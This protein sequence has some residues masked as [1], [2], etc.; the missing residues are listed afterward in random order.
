MCLLKLQSCCYVD[1]LQKYRIIVST[2]GWV[3]SNALYVD[4]NIVQRVLSKVYQPVRLINALAAILQEMQVLIRG[5]IV[6]F[7]ASSNEAKKKMLGPNTSL[8]EA[9]YEKGNRTNKDPKE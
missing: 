3:L 5:V 1:L 4:E 2:S 7:Y 8:P 9:V 6:G